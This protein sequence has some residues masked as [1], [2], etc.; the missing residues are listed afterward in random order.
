MKNFL[1]KIQE[2]LKASLEKL[3]VNKWY[4]LKL[5]FMILFGILVTTIVC[6]LII[7]LLI[8]A[9]KGIGLLF[10]AL[11]PT[12]VVVGC[13]VIAFIS[14]YHKLYL[15]HQERVE[16]KE[17]RKREEQKTQS[18]RTELEAKTNYQ[19]LTMFLFNALDP[20]ICKQLELF[21]PLVPSELRDFTPIQ[22]EERTQIV[23]YNFTIKKETELP[24]SKGL[25][26]TKSILSSVIMSRVQL[27]GIEGITP[28]T[29]NDP[30]IVLYVDD[31]VDRG[32]DIRVTLVLNT[33]EYRKHME[34]NGNPRED[35]FIE[36]I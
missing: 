4:I 20:R 2:M 23:Y 10:D 22:I 25:D 1:D 31:V 33:E 21:K 5:L 11:L 32:L 14:F 35:S 6:N 36:H 27:Q 3:K 16:M 34:Q 18:N 29:G 9:I 24:F 28:P 15:Q 26:R 8:I 19:H 17:N 7:Q 13:V 30:E 12:L